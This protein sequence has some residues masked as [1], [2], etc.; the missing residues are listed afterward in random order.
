[1]SGASGKR[2][3]AGGGGGG[4]AAGAGGGRGGDGAGGALRVAGDE[5]TRTAQEPGEGLLVY[6]GFR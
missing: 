4:G 2:A 6:F 3:R 5:G 1:M